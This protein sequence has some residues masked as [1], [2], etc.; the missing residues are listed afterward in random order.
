MTTTA[1]SDFYKQLDHI[2]SA[3]R[4]ATAN[5]D[6]EVGTQS[7]TLALLLTQQLIDQIMDTFPGVLA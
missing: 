2:T 3:L 6:D 7:A 4:T 1:M 5:R